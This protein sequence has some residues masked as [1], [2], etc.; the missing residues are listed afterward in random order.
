MWPSLVTAIAMAYVHVYLDRESALKYSNLW[1]P[2][3]VSGHLVSVH[4]VKRYTRSI[5]RLHDPVCA[6]GVVQLIGG[7]SNL[8]VIQRTPRDV[9][10]LTTI[11]WGRNE[12]KVMDMRALRRWYDTAF[13]DDLYDTLDDDVERD[14]W[15]RSSF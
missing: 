6:G 9:V 14:L 2:Q 10:L 8:F 15:H 4:D 11:L 7:R 1:K 5:V 3:A 13:V 12:Q